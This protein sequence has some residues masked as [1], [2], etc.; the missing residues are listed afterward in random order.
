MSGDRRVRAAVMQSGGALA[1]EAIDLAAL[2]PHDV[3]VSTR[4]A[5]V[6]LTDSIARRGTFPV[7]NAPQIRG[8]GGVGVV[9]EVGS[10]V[11]RVRPGDRVIAAVRL[12]CGECPLCLGGQAEWCVHS[13]GPPPRTVDVDGRVYSDREPPPAPVGR[14]SAGDPLSAHARIGSYADMMRVP[15]IAVTPVRAEVPDAELALLACGAGTGLGAVFNQSGVRAGATTAVVGCGVVGLSM[16]LALRLLGA[17][18]IVAVDPDPGRRELALSM[19]ATAAAGPAE[20]L[21][22]ALVATRAVGV[23][24]AFEAAGAPEAME[25]A[26]AAT[27]RGGG[28]VLTG[29]GSPDARVTF[30]MNELA[31]RGRRVLGSQFG[32]VQVRRDLPRLAALVEH[33]RLELAPLITHR[34]PLDD[35]HGAIDAVEHRTALGAVIDRF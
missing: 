32:A 21:D 31:V 17:R 33:G 8:H 24:V 12:Q 2:G 34:F 35:L 10:A 20:A 23:D 5:V 22:C 7:F 30:A 25:L 6:C 26:F 13:D 15:D 9:I 16:V 27:R 4:A 19:G 18:H 3:F 29:F 1:I 14:T 11:T 28:V